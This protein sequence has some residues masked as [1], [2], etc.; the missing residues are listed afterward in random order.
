MPI[1]RIQEMDS[2]CLRDYT[3]RPGKTPE[4][5]AGARQE[6]MGVKRYQD[7]NTVENRF[8]AYFAGKVLHLECFRYEQDGAVAHADQIRKFRQVID[9]FRQEPT[10][11]EIRAQHFQLTKPNYVLQQ[12]PIY[13]SFYQ[14]YLDYICKRSEK[15]RVWSFRTQLLAD[16]I[17]LLLTAALL[18][19]RGASLKPLAGIETRTSPDQGKYLSLSS[20]SPPKIQI[21]LQQEVYEFRLE[22]SP[23]LSRGDYQLTVEFQDLHSPSLTTNEEQFP[24]WVFWYKPS[25]DLITQA[26]QY[27]SSLPATCPV[28]LLFYLQQSPNPSS[29]ISELTQRTERLWLCQIANPIDAGGFAGAVEFLAAEVV[30]KL[31]EKR[32]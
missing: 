25:D 32:N 27:L 9:C 19:F 14:A 2:Y 11:Q 1:G 13:S 15:E 29:P 4:E 8:L 6:L 24:I 22:Q 18:R 16:T 10:V 20:G 17:Y 3:R 12:N 23:D 7:Y 30:Q 26:Q 5:K 21:F 31:V 28:G